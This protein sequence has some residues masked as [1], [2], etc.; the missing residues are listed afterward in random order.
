MYISVYIWS[1]DVHSWIYQIPDIFR[2]EHQIFQLNIQ[3]KI[4][5]KND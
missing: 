3:D 4:I 2:S 5:L 1:S